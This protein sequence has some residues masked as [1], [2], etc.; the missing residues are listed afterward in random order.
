MDSPCCLLSDG[1]CNLCKLEIDDNE[2]IQCYRC[3]N[4]FHAL[5]EQSGDKICNKTLLGLYLQKSTKKNFVWYCDSCLTQIE[6]SNTVSPSFYTQKVDDLEGKIDLL[7]AKVSSITD[8]IATNDTGNPF[9]EGR[10]FGNTSN[11]ANSNNVWGNVSKVTILKNNLGSSAKLNELEK[12]VVDDKIQITHAKRNKNG[13]VVIT[14]PNSSAASQVKHIALQVLPDHSVKDPQVNYSW[15]NVVGFEV[16]HSTSDIHDLLVKHNAVFDC[17]KN[18]TVD[19]AKE[20]MEVKVVK[21]CLKNPSVFRALLKVSKALR[22]L[23]KLGKDKLRIGLFS[24]TVYD[25][26][27]QIKRCNRCQHF[28]HWVASCDASNGKA[29]AKCASLDH[30]TQ[31]C[32]I[33]RNYTTRIKCINCIRQ[34]LM[35]TSPHTADSPTCPCFVN[36]KN[37]THTVPKNRQ[38]GYN[39]SY[40]HQSGNIHPMAQVN[41]PQ[42]FQPLT[43]AYNQTA[44][45]F[46][47]VTSV[48]NQTAPLNQPGYSSAYGSSNQYVS[49][50]CLSSAAHGV[51]PMPN[52]SQGHLNG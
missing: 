21:P 31:N 39:F 36:H 10:L 24:C 49:N 33:D 15:I 20:F 52:S 13:D 26:S 44:Q 42:R 51:F 22:K 46:N 2:T 19:Q 50:N 11:Q 40:Q 18:K 14:C 43:S 1:T 47:P 37:Q 9:T 8:V 6:V 35:Y 34:G 17:L 48:Y 23:I 7:T 32:N 3:K 29:C 12:R 25:Q 27:P 30:E 28:G 41:V 5:C 4:N 38:T 16:S 45:P